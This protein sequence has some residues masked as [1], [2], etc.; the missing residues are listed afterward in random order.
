MH[1]IPVAVA[2][3]IIMDSQGRILLLRRRP[4]SS[5]AG[6]WCLPGGKVDY[7]VTVT[8]AMRDE[9]AEETGL[10]CHAA[11]FLFYQDTLPPA[12]G[13][14]HCINF[15]FQCDVAGEVVLNDESTAHAWVLPAELTAYD[16]AFRNDEGIQRYLDAVNAHPE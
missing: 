9:I 12:P 6:Q 7:G 5:G 10:T 11:E 13:D 2:R 4:G 8:Q 1:Q 3:A 15:Y 14:M 16:M